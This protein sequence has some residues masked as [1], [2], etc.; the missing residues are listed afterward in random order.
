MKSSNQGKL[1]HKYKADTII[2]LKDYTEWLCLVNDGDVHPG[3]HSAL[4]TLH[5][6]IIDLYSDQLLDKGTDTQNV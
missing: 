5:G 2:A 4:M 6:A 3:L 1:R